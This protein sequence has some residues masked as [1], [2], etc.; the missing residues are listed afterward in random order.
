MSDTKKH[1]L[2]VSFNLFLQKSFKEV[3][4]KEIVEKTG[5][6]KGAFYHYFESKEQLFLEIINNALSTLLDIDYSRFSKDSLYQFYHDYIASSNNIR[7]SL[8]Q[9]RRDMDN[10]LVLNHY[11][12]FFEALR[13]FPSFRKK[14][15]EYSQ[16]ELKA[17]MEIVQFARNKGEITSPMNDE[18]IA[19]MFIYATDGL[20]MRNIMIGRK[21]NT[22]ESLLELWDSFYKELKT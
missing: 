1:I 16:I 18:Q 3:T 10:G 9:N 11:S 8:L 14:V 12:L 22:R 5:M 4:M 19:S 17:W 13:F 7:S 6:S 21:E 15:L 20:G 2:N